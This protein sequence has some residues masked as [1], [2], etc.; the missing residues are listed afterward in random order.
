MSTV[1]NVILMLL[2]GESIYLIYSGFKL[3]K[4]NKEEIETN[5]KIEDIKVELINISDEK[6]EV[7]RKID[8]KN[9]KFLAINQMVK[10]LANEKNVNELKKL[11]MDMLLEVNS[12]RRGVSFQRVNNIMK[13]FEKKN[14]EKIINR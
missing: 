4:L 8:E 11:I 12:V 6:E 2:I 9:F 1:S 3:K 14:M 10:T 7:E 5:K 13:I